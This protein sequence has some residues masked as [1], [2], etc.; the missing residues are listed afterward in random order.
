[1]SN[2]DFLPREDSQLQN[3]LDNFLSA[4]VKNDEVLQLDADQINTI[5][6]QILG[7]DT[8]MTN[9]TATKAAAKSAVTAKN[10]AKSTI[11]ATVRTFAKQFKADPTIP[12]SVLSELGIVANAGNGPVVTVSSLT[13]MGCDDGVNKLKWDRNGNASG[14]LFIIE[15][16]LQGQANWGIAGAV[17]KSSFDHVDQEPGQTVYYRVVST[18]GGQ[19]SNPTSAVVAYGNSSG[20]GLSVAA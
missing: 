13:V 18:R 12:A 17:T 16:K 1:M 11:S 8:G 20:P 6:T 14:T 3:W 15:Y 5:N 10:T 2:N 19:T 7:F 4:C 9:V